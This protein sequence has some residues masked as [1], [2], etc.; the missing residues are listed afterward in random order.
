MPRDPVL[1]FLI[2]VSMA[3]VFAP[4]PAQAADGVPAMDHVIVIVMENHSYDEVRIQTYTASLIQDGTSFSDSHGVTHPSQPNY[5]ALWSGS[6]QGVSNDQCP[7]PGQPYSGE[8]LGHAC[9]AAG[10][11]WKAYSED[12]PSAGSTVCSANSS[13]YTRKHDPWTDFSNVDHTGEV[14]FSQLALD[15]AAGALPDLA[16]V[17]P[18]NCDNSHDCSVATAD[19]WLSQHVPAMLDAVGA[20][21]LVIL[22]WDEDDFTAA[23]HILT[24][25]QGVL[26]KSG[27][28]STHHLTHYTVLRTICDVLGLPPFGAATA[29][30]SMTDIW[31]DASGVPTLPASWGRIKALYGG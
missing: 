11:T 5:L 6:T 10:L 30:S 23:N 25:F 1:S 19:A 31:N 14:P 4:G 12:L 13:A 2:A 21:G 26:V 9:E 29:E 20:R 18:N 16:F 17:I 7:P 22:T 24:V 15:E 27:N 28:V 3:A 8:N